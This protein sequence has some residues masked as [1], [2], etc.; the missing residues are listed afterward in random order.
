[1]IFFEYYGKFLSMIR[2]SNKNIGLYLVISA[3]WECINEAETPGESA[4]LAIEE[5]YEKY[6]K[7]LNLAPTIT[8]FSISS[9]LDGVNFMDTIISHYTPAVLSNAGLHNL[10]KSYKIILSKLINDS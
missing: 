4:T 5:A 9:S 6:G 10:S 7:N 1:M 3:D 8:T 2:K